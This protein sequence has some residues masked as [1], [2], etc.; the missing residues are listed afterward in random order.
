M[1][2]HIYYI[3]QPHTNYRYSNLFSDCNKNQFPFLQALQKAIS[4]TIFPAAEVYIVGSS[5]NGFGRK[6][7]DLDMCL[8]LDRNTNNSQVKSYL[9]H[10]FFSLH[11]IIFCQFL[12]TDERT[13]IRKWIFVPRVGTIS[14]YLYLR[15]Y[16]FLPTYRIYSLMCSMSAYYYCTLYNNRLFVPT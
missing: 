14:G 3:L 15:R 2:I 12:L 8:M 6:T 7:S 9:V 10:F 13:Y 5:I 16:L 1:N 4:R 11:S